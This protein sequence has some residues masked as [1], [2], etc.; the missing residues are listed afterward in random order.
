MNYPIDC[1]E[2][3][4]FKGQKKA[5]RIFQTVILM[6]AVVGFGVG[7]YFEKFS[8]TV[9]TLGVGFLLSCLVSIGLSLWSG[10]GNVSFYWFCVSCLGGPASLADVPKEP[11]EVAKAHL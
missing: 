5:E 4:D 3:Q 10:I 9:F 2:S 1:I 6:F 11:L 8:Y 7:L